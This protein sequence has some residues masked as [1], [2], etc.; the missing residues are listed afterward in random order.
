M[1]RNRKP[2]PLV[3]MVLSALYFIYVISLGSSTMIGDEVGGDPGGMVLPL[4]LAI[5]MFLVS[6]ALFA[7]DRKDPSSSQGG[8]TSSQKR[9]FALTAVVSL[10]YV[11]LARPLGYIL[12]TLW[13]LYILTFYY[14]QGDVVLKDLK[15]SLI[16]F[17]SST[18]VML[19][20]YSIGRKITRSLLLAARKGSIPSLLGSPSAVAGITLVVVTALFVALLFLSRKL[21]AKW[22]KSG[23]V[24][25]AHISALVAIATT[26]FIYLIFRQLFLVE[27]VR[28]IITW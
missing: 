2:L 10:L 18:V 15:V 12:T 17:V 11:V 1:F 25:S 28:G 4:F 5:F 19:A 3:S 23:S 20:L 13:L 7:T 27:L 9:L 14:I 26:E 16:G 22:G 6:A 24:H 21:L 8:M